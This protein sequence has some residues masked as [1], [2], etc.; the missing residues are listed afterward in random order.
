MAV[1]LYRIA[2]TNASTA[3]SVVRALSVPPLPGQRI[4][5]DERTTLIV[6]EVVADGGGSIT[7]HVLADKTDTDADSP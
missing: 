1:P 7:A 4:T 2:Y 5:I 3:H 6:R